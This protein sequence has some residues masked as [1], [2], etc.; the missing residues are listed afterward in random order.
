MVMKRARPRGS[1]SRVSKYAMRKVPSVA[2][3]RNVVSVVRNSFQKQ[4][5]GLSGP[6][7]ATVAT[8]PVG[9][10]CVAI[11]QGDGD[12]NRSG[13]RIRMQ[14]ILWKGCVALPNAEPANCVELYLV[15][16]LQTQSDTIPAYS[17]IFDSG[18]GGFV[19][20]SSTVRGR[21]KILAHKKLVL[22]PG[23]QFTAGVLPVA[24]REF[25]IYKKLNIPVRYNGGNDTDLQA[26]AIFA[27]A[28]CSGYTTTAPHYLD[29]NNS[30][31][32]I[33]FIDEA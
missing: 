17:D 8:P 23:T 32:R 26:N 12:T 10:S 6:T 20:L 33:R 4:M 21:F 31:I 2:F 5:R 13:N 16:D 29:A 28:V 1:R 19:R 3:K 22:N 9:I 7:I 11:A 25:Q 14:S 15:Q 27:F 24:T 30:N 18:G